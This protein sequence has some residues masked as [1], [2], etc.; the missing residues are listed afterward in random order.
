MNKLPKALIYSNPILLKNKSYIL[1]S[2]LQ[3]LRFKAKQ[4]RE[5]PYRQGY[6]RCIFLLPS[7]NTAVLKEELSGP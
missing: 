6:V 1:H 4:P 7:G 2:S 3:F 5:Q